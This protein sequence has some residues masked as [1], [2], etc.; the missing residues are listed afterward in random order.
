M[1]GM[2]LIPELKAAADAVYFTDT[3]KFQGIAKWINQGRKHGWSEKSMAEALRQ[4]KSGHYDLVDEWYPYLDT[5]L[6]RIVK[7]RN[8][9][10]S[11]EEHRR[12][13]AELKELGNSAR[14]GGDPLKPV[15]SVVRGLS[16]AKKA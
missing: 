1:A 6:D 13:L 4:F 9:D 8:R 7:D 11:D 3:K 10:A 16:D 5:I 14:N 15:F 2:N 12:H